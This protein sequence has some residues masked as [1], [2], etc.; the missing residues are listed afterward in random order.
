MLRM[1]CELRSRSPESD[2]VL[3]QRR[4]DRQVGSGLCIGVQPIEI[5]CALGVVAK[6]ISGKN[7]CRR[8]LCAFAA[9]AFAQVET[10]AGTVIQNSAS[11]SFTDTNGATAALSAIR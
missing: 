1:E 10:P 11:V 8:V 7:C 3:S 2:G 6:V 9:S 4:K 5:L